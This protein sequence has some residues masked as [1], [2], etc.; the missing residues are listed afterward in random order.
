MTEEVVEA[1]V[2]TPTPD[3]PRFLTTETLNSTPLTEIASRIVQVETDEL[4]ADIGA[5]GPE[6]EALLSLME[7]SSRSLL[8]YFEE[9]GNGQYGASDQIN[10]PTF[11]KQAAKQDAMYRA[12]NAHPDDHASRINAFK[13]EADRIDHLNDSELP[14]INYLAQAAGIV[15]TE[16]GII[17]AES[18]G[19]NLD[20]YKTLFQLPDS[21]KERLLKEVDDLG[22][23]S[24]PEARALRVQAQINQ[25]NWLIT[26]IA[27]SVN[28]EGRRN[29]IDPNDPDRGAL[30]NTF[31]KMAATEGMGQVILDLDQSEAY[32]MTSR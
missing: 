24:S 22:P 18:S 16:H 12:R 19:V 11:R 9:K 4:C 27:T 31:G 32:L 23:N 14:D 5:T 30:L 26:N 3:R 17:Y 2:I 28:N 7:D 15:G 20:K 13:A 6:R 8:N 10:N 1:T 21:E 29:R 25:T